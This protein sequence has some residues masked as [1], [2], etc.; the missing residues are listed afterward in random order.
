VHAA[1]ALLFIG[2]VHACQGDGE[3]SGLG[4]EI[5][6]TVSVRVALLKDARLS[7]PWAT[8]EDRMVVM[9]AAETFE[10]ARTAAV[11]SMLAAFV[12]QLDRPRASRC[13]GSAVA[14]RRPQARGRLGRVRDD[15]SPR[16][17]ELTWHSSAMTSHQADRPGP[18]SYK[19]LARSAGRAT[20][21]RQGSPHLAPGSRYD[22]T[23]DGEAV[24]QVASSP[25]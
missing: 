7:W 11:D 19:D 3:V 6:A 18:F 21:G 20:L 22:E 13:A 14:C 16:S 17:P 9:T 5:P 23:L 8:A 2:D 4:L 12:S 25:I 10:E 1:G 15:G 24:S